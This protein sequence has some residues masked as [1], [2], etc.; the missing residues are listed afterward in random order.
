MA[1]ANESH[2]LFIHTAFIS[3]T[4]TEEVHTE[5]NSA[6][7][8]KFNIW[9]KTCGWQHH[10]CTFSKICEKLLLNI[11][12]THAECSVSSQYCLVTRIGI[13][14]MTGFKTAATGDTERADGRLLKQKLN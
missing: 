13:I 8:C 4:H 9:I 5:V 6:F 3:E 10:H 11:D 7:M 12:V 1:M 14:L 2:F